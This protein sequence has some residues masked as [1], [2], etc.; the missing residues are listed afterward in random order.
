MLR[1]EGG[2][3]GASFICPA[4]VMQASSHPMWLNF[5]AAPLVSGKPMGGAA[6]VE[7]L[8]QKTGRKLAPRKVEKAKLAAADQRQGKLTFAG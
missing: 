2:L 3:L 1:D 5:A 4:A 7:E 8:G 6:F